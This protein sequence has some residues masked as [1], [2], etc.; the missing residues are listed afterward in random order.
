MQK[1]FNIDNFKAMAEYKRS[2]SKPNKFLVR[3]PRPAGLETEWNTV[4]SDLEF[5]CSGTNLPGVALATHDAL[6]YH[7]GAR[8]KR[9]FAPIFQDVMLNLHLDGKGDYYKFFSRW[10]MSIC[11]FIYWDGPS[12]PSGN[13]GGAEQFPWEVAYKG[14]YAVEVQIVVFTDTGAVSHYVVLRDAFPTM[15]ADTRLDWGDNSGIV[16]LPIIMTYTDWYIKSNED[17]EKE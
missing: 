4:T 3:I 14:D 11:N 1:G 13:V 7:Y 8:E 10:I 2:F 12:K 9:P 16:K 17:F 6:R 5:W 15:I